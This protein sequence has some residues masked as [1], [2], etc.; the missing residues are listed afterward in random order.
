VIRPLVRLMVGA[1]ALA[2]TPLVAATTISAYGLTFTGGTAIATTGT[3]GNSAVYTATAADGTTISATVTAWNATLATSGANAGK[4]LVTQAYLGQY[5]NGLGI[6]SAGNDTPTGL[7]CILGGCGAQQIDNMGNARG[8]SSFDFL[9]LSFSAPVAL[10]SISRVA[11]WISDGSLLGTNYD[12]D[13]SYGSSSTAL[14]NGMALASLTTLMN[15][16]VAAAGACGSLLTLGCNDT[17]TLTTAG[18]AAA[19]A[20]AATQDWYVGANIGSNYG[21]DN[22]VDGFSLTGATVYGAPSG[23]VPEASTWMMMILG[24]GAI[25]I[26]IRRK[27]SATLT[28]ELGL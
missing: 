4:Y 16:N 28:R 3:A 11:G 14:S 6:T 7:S 13:F 15:T 2:S 22:L 21:G 20:A 27:G 24:F 9:R 1:C 19:I 18:D 26:A 17:S 8:S 25:G 23:A 5:S 10:G 12:D